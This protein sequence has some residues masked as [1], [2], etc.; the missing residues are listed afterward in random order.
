MIGVVGKYSDPG[1]EKRP[2]VGVFMA[3][4]L[5]GWRFG[6]VGVLFVCIRVLL[7]SAMDELASL[8]RMLCT[9]KVWLYAVGGRDMGDST[10]ISIMLR[11]YGGTTMLRFLALEGFCFSVL[12]GVDIL[13]ND[14]ERPGDE[15]LYN[16]RST[17]PTRSGRSSY[18]VS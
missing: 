4:P 13:Y 14:G 7:T 5:P 17:A 11:S 8:A 16:T 6:D 15:I 12:R 3:S 18:N 2:G 10:S 9:P 1:C